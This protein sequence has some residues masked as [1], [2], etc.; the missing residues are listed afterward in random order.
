V[1][2]KWGGDV[3]A[4]N[5]QRPIN[6]FTKED[7]SFS[8]LLSLKSVAEFAKLLQEKIWFLLRA[9]A[10]V[11]FILSDNP[12]VRNNYIDYWPRESLGLKQDGIEVYLPVS[13]RLAVQF[14]CPKIATL[15]RYI[16]YGQ[17]M[18]RFQNEGRPVPLDTDNVVFVNSLQVIYSE[19]F[20]YAAHDRDFQLVKEMLHD[21]PDLAR[22]A[23]EKTIS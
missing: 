18:L 8:S 14:V 1:I 16:P 6:A 15:L 2:S 19:R 21:H 23:S 10:D 12:V 20:L 3:R 22:P 11:S 7:S 9:P 5:D 17:R 13:P 4:G